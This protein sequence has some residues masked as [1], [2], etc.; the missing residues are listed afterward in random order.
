MHLSP[1]V[2]SVG[3]HGTVP[4]LDAVRAIERSP[5]STAP[6][7]TGSSQRARESSEKVDIVACWAGKLDSRGTPRGMGKTEWDAAARNGM[8][9][10]C[11]KTARNGVG[12]HYI[13]SYLWG[14][15][16]NWESRAM[17]HKNIPHPCKLETH[18]KPPLHARYAECGLYQTQISF[19]AHGRPPE[20]C[21]DFSRQSGH[22]RLPDTLF[23]VGTTRDPVITPR[24]ARHE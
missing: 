24:P 1:A 6:L 9:N 10:S 16:G 15:C 17:L 14:S 4:R 5:H 8:R 20:K 21:S 22:S 13:E 12:A 18:N 2:A 3:I 7:G 23:R 19:P 11:R